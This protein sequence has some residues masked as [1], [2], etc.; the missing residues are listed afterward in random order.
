MPIIRANQSGIGFPHIYEIYFSLNGAKTISYIGRASGENPAYLSGSSELNRVIANTVL[1]FGEEQAELGWH[2]V[3]LS[4]FPCDTPE[5]VLEEEEKRLIVESYEECRRLGPGRNWEI[6][7][8][9]HLRRYWQSDAKAVLVRLREFIERQDSADKRLV[10]V[11][12]NTSME[13]SFQN[14]C[15]LPEQKEEG[16]DHWVGDRPAK[17][18]DFLEAN[19]LQR[20]ASKIGRRVPVSIS[21]MAH[22]C[23]MRTSIK[24]RVLFAVLI[25]LQRSQRN[26][27]QHYAIRTSTLRYLLDEPNITAPGLRR[28][29]DDLFS[30]VGNDEQVRVS[31]LSLQKKL[32][33][34]L[35]ECS[36]VSVAQSA[37]MAS[38]D[39]EK[40]MRVASGGQQAALG[41]RYFA[42]QA[43]YQ[44]FQ[45]TGQG[46]PFET[47]ISLISGRPIP[48]AG[49]LEK[50]KEL[51]SSCSKAIKSSE[52]SLREALGT[53][54]AT[55][56][57]TKK[58]LR[59]IQDQFGNVNSDYQV[60][61]DNSETPF[62]SFLVVLSDPASL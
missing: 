41:R 52:N 57:F 44:Y 35:V 40:F 34:F 26:L 45:N 28:I 2:K 27:R 3:I 20:A 58:K 8:K 21:M 37:M 60:L 56:Y 11:S 29:F 25:E 31:E 30:A 38:I 61:V 59:Q 54:F 33:Q 4:E 13:R 15:S 10:P 18:A 7:N 36:P 17:T 22:P 14:S 43:A 32:A 49:E 16:D 9:E 19:F 51:Q 42:I 12:L 62:A 39:F 55:N 53:A 50:R 47:A 24:M 48:G 1:C 23:L 5:S 6:L 46:L